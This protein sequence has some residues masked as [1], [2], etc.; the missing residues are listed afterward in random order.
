MVEQLLE[1]SVLLCGPIA[2]S[3]GLEHFD[4][5]Y[6]V[7]RQLEIELR[8]RSF[9]DNPVPEMGE[10]RGRKAEDEV[11]QLRGRWWRGFSRVVFRHGCRAVS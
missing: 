7:P 9:R 1:D 10:S 2:F 6:G 3:L 8:F 5:V 4:S 11:N